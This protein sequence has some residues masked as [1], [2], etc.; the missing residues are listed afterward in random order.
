MP[1]AQEVQEI[2]P[3]L[4][5]WQAYDSKV[6]ADLFSTALETNAG[7]YLVDPI[8]LTSK[9][10]LPFRTNRPQV[11]G[12]FVTN[13]NHARAATDF[14]KTFSVPLYVHGELHGSPD[15]LQAT[16]VEDGE[17]FS[18]GLTA[19]AIDGG[20][21]GEMAVHYNDNG[22]TMVV[23]DALINFEPHGFGLLPT[24]YCLN[25]KLMRRS[26]EKL[27]DYPFERVLFAHG[28]PILA[29]ARARLEQLLGAI[30]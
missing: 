15:F 20:P 9:G 12:I 3:G 25:S 2:S 13:A 27:L 26:L 22:G 8:P 11:A 29:R 30:R 4:L 10:L 6:K 1:S 18:N 28:T 17:V 23:G 19:V 14:A 5:V 16:G 21:A 24:K 7:T